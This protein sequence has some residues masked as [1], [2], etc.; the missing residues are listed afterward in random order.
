[1]DWRPDDGYRVLIV[2]FV[3]GKGGIGEAMPTGLKV[4]Y[5]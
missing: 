2:V 1:M 4:N 3:K 5:P